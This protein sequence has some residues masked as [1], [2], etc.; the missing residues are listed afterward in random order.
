MS[1]DE[2]RKEKA[3]LLL[4]IKETRAE[5]ACVASKLDRAHGAASRLA[6]GLSAADRPQFTDDDSRT[7]QRSLDDLDACGDVR[8]LVAELLALDVRL[9]RLERREA[10]IFGG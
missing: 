5:R 9:D 3:Y 6:Q 1:D 4:E 2:M 8:T 7:V 10:Q